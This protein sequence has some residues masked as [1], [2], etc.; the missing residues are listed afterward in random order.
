MTIRLFL[1][2][3]FVLIGTFAL[4]QVKKDFTHQ[5]DLSGKYRS[6]RYKQYTSDYPKIYDVRLNYMPTV[7]FDT[8][9]SVSLLVGFDRNVINFRN[10][11]NFER[12]H[13]V[14][15]GIHTGYQFNRKGNHPFQIGGNFSLFNDFV[16]TD[17]NGEQK[18]FE[19]NGFETAL[20]IAP[21]LR[22]HGILVMPK[23]SLIYRERESFRDLNNEAN[24]YTLLGLQFM[25]G[26]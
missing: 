2:I 13:T 18:T 1:L 15:Y 11:L 6:I 21:V 20:Y 3:P 7:L 22:W 19:Q 12:V 9:Y 8:S 5:F 24:L 14:L 17:H 16:F 23:L 25:F 4:G 26:L 10:S